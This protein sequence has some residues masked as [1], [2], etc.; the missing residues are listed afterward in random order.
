MRAAAIQ[1]QAAPAAPP[2]LR[3]GAV[4]DPAEREADAVA[5]RILAGGDRVAPI[6]RR[7]A[8]G[9]AVGMHAAA[10]VAAAMA[11]HGQALGSADAGFFGAALGI[12][13]GSVRVH[14][15]AEAD[16]AARSVG[17][18]AFALGE[19][20]VFAT[21][22]YRP[23]TRAGRHLLAHELA[24]VAQGDGVLR[25]FTRAEESEISTLDEV[26]AQA[27]QRADATADL[28]LMMSWGRFV[29]ANGGMAAQEVVAGHAGAASR[30]A[31][32]T[33]PGASARPARTNSKRY[34]F[35]CLCGLVDMRHF[36]QLMYIG[37]LNGNQEAVAEGREHEL[38]A[39]ATSRFAAEDSPSNALGAYFGSQ[40]SIAE[41]RS[42]FVANLR[43]YLAH[44]HPI[45][46]R[47]LPVD[48]RNAILD[49]YAVDGTSPPAHPN[50]AAFPNMERIPACSGL[51]MFPFV[52]GRGED[53]IFNRIEGVAGS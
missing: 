30:A 44:C 46:Y 50:Q 24:H 22:A 21:G 10:P 11:G 5:A 17:A 37:L 1:P 47:A 29:A 53:R 41:R 48:Q 39:E 34:M 18:R 19:H 43:A 45:D 42:V 49:W 8:A 33:G 6:I 52:L 51:G 13:A 31:G 3:I 35:S 23:T 40:Q 15:G 4:D 28:P 25:R 26:V 20:L 32:G 16:A 2:P 7:S 12:D 38:T 36:Y 9:G 14:T 27:Q